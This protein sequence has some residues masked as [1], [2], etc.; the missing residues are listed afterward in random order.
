MGTQAGAPAQHGHSRVKALAIKM[1]L[2][3]RNPH[4]W[5]GQVPVAGYSHAGVTLTQGWVE[6]GGAGSEDKFRS[7]STASGRQALCLHSSAKYAENLY[8][9]CV[10]PAEG[11]YRQPGGFLRCLLTLSETKTRFLGKA[12]RKATVGGPA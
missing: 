4:V 2:E 11:G 12:V 7:K 6:R 8:T 9:G 5:E 1:G 10:G 3:V